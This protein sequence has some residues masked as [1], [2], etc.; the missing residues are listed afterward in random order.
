MEPT[1]I[2]E[3]AALSPHAIAKMLLLRREIHDWDEKQKQAQKAKILCGLNNFPTL[4]EGQ[5]LFF[6]FRALLSTADNQPHGPQKL[7]KS[8]I[9]S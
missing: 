5:W 2:V 3:V 9:N 4:L 8:I 7:K 1:V 6:T